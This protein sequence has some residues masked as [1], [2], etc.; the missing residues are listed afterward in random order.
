MSDPHPEPGRPAP[1]PYDPDENLIGYIERDQKPPA[2]RPLPRGSRR[3][4]PPDEKPET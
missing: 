1:P 3:E 2:G 4:R